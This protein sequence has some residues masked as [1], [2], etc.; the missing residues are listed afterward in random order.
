MGASKPASLS[1][2]PKHPYRDHQHYT[3]RPEETIAVVQPGNGLEVHS[4]YASYYGSGSQKASN[5]GNY[6]HH[7][8]NPQVYVV[9]IEVLHAHHHITI[10]FTK[11]ISLYDVIINI[12]KVFSRA[13]IQQ[14]TFTS[15]YAA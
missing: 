7:F 6:L 1:E 5:N 11:I 13:V 4:K 8:I 2:C 9:D 15:L 10:V 12:F 14:V 3:Y